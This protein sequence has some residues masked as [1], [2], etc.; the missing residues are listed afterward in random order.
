MRFN[1]ADNANIIGRNGRQISFSDL[2]P[3]MRVRVRH[4]NFM[5]ASI[6]PQTTAYGVRVLGF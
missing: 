3:G 6:P 4:A 5:T 1:L 2:N